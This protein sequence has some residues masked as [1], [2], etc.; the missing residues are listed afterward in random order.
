[1][2]KKMGIAAIAVL[3]AAL[4]VPVLAIAVQKGSD[5]PENGAVRIDTVRPEL[6]EKE[7]ESPTAP[8][9]NTVEC[10]GISLKIPKGWEY[11]IEENENDAIC[12]ISLRPAGQTGKIAVR[13]YPMFG[14]CGNG[15]SEKEISLGAYRAWQGTYDNRS[16]WDFMVIK[17]DAAEG[18]YVVLN[19]GIDAWWGEFGAEAMRILETLTIE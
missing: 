8:A 10:A 15:L 6:E 9:E 13:Y 18:K 11:E 17:S 1:M 5:L 12:G 16:V 7:R 4:T 3:L 14:V 19:E 2:K